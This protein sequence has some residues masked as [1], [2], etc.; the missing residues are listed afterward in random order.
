MRGG[1]SGDC[2]EGVVG[3]V[4][5]MCVGCVNRDDGGDQNNRSIRSRTWF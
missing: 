1:G 2:G 5:S 3:V 4:G